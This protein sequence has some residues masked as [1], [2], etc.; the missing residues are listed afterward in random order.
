MRVRLHESKRKEETQRDIED[1]ARRISGIQVTQ[2][3]QGEVLLEG[4]KSEFWVAVEKLKNKRESV[5]NNY[6]EGDSFNPDTEKKYRNLG[7]TIGTMKR[8]I[9]NPNHGFRENT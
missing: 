3:K 4:S 9:K 2:S 7:G 8:V 1:V 5:W 6:L